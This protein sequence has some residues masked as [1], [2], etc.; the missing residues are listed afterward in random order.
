MTAPAEGRF[1]GP[2][3]PLRVLAAE[4]VERI[5]EASLDVLAG[6][7]V[8]FHSQGALDVLEDHGAVVDRGA[9]I[10]RIP[11]ATVTEAQ[12]GRI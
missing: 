11:P 12:S 5:H 2:R 3:R 6:T 8:M 4:D 9:T 1:V 10:A 7:G